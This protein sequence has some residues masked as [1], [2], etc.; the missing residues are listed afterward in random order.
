MIKNLQKN[1]P[2]LEKIGQKGNFLT[3]FS[4]PSLFQHEGSS[5]EWNSIQI[6]C[7]KTHNLRPT[8]KIVL[9]YFFSSLYSTS[10]RPRIFRLLA[11]QVSVFS[12]F[13]ILSLDH[14]LVF[15]F[16]ID[17]SVF[18]YSTLYFSASYIPSMWYVVI[19]GK[20][21]SVFVAVCWLC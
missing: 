8:T 14:I 2:N 17:R 21:V 5:I 12:F 19:C 20:I 18:L 16:R 10:Y 11:F 13:S 9:P 7:E 15:H 3:N 1:W 6:R 4:N